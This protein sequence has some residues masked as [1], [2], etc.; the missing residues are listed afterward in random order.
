MLRGLFCLVRDSTLTRIWSTSEGRELHAGQLLLRPE[1][2]D[3][4]L[5][6]LEGSGEG[7]AGRVLAAQHGVLVLQERRLELVIELG[8]RHRGS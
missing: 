6:V 5:E 7:R 8:Q 4:V 1:L 2:V 3:L